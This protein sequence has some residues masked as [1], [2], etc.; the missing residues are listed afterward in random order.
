M[1]SIFRGCASGGDDDQY[2][3]MEGCGGGGDTARFV[4]VR[5]WKLI[6]NSVSGEV[7]IC[8]VIFFHNFAR[9]EQS[10]K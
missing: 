8:S 2:I 10:E 5:F 7:E 3:S 4:T 9:A 6:Y 1:E